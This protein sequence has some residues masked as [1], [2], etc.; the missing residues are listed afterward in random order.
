MTFVLLL[1]DNGPTPW[2]QCCSRQCDE[3]LLLADADA[4]PDRSATERECL[5]TAAGPHRRRRDPAAAPSGGMPVAVRH[6][7]MAGG[8]AA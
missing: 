4:S 6:R 8:G 1:A 2:T 5:A 3:L 7:R